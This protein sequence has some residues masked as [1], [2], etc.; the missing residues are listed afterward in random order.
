MLTDFSF[1]SPNASD[2]CISFGS[3]PTVSEPFDELFLSSASRPSMS[4]AIIGRL[5]AN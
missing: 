3:E 1:L 5:L 2:M 4:I